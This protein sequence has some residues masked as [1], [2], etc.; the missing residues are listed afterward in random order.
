MA[1]E[2]KS[3][4]QILSDTQ[5]QLDAAFQRRA[6][7]PD[8]SSEVEKLLSETSPFTPTFPWA[9]ALGFTALGVTLGFLC[10]G[11]D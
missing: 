1:T 3:I 8:Y 4:D 5:N 6:N 11:L 9:I 10:W 2:T 7:L